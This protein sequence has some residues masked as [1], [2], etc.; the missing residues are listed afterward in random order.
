MENS[1]RYLGLGFGASKT[2]GKTSLLFLNSSFFKPLQHAESLIEISIERIAL[3]SRF[4]LFLTFWL[5]VTILNLCTTLSVLSSWDA[6]SAHFGDLEQRC[7]NKYFR[8]SLVLELVT[9]LEFV[10]WYDPN[11]QPEVTAHIYRS[12]LTNNWRCHET[13]YDD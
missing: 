6:F 12:L 4:G 11:D 8:D 13:R 3:P 7:L 1:S 2:F 5:L 9:S 10:N